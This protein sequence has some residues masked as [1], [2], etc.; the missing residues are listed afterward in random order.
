MARLLFVPMS[1]GRGMGPLED[2]LSV[3]KQASVLGHTVAFVCR[4]RFCA[5]PAQAGYRVYPNA[6]P[7]A[8][9]TIDSDL[10]NVDFPV[11]QGL[12]EEKWVRKILACE[13]AAI[14]DFRPHAV[15]TWLQFTAAI[16][17]RVAGVPI[18]SV[19]RWT[20]HPEFASPL[21][22]GRFLRSGC[23][24]LFNRILAEYELPLI[25]DVW[26][27]DFFRSDLKIVAGTPELE[28]GLASVSNLYYV[29]HLLPS[30]ADKTKLSQEL[31]RWA[32]GYPAVFVYL[33]VKQFQPEEYCPIIRKAF[34]GSEFRAV[35][36]VGL[37]DICPELPESTSNVRFVRWIPI[38]AMMSI[39]DVVVSTGTRGT[40][41]QAALHGAG[42]VAFPGKDP[43]RDFVA[44]MLETAGAGIRLPDEAFTPKRI[45]SAVRE[46]LNPVTR[47][48]AKVLGDQLR[49]LGG[50]KRAAELLVR[51]AQGELGG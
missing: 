47:A 18:A 37:K 20:G 9:P 42:H 50:P 15:F 46:V 39:S 48:H 34:D 5:L 44:R 11:F 38:D 17:A 6:T 1:W 36:A 10:F 33:S 29:G 28:P 12:G 2:C 16:S 35:V 43:E 19:A 25:D 51:L 41:W 45:L 26:E 13:F 14:E 40:S 8:P 30:E 31:T 24:P 4:E 7:P 21:L 49:S 32:L 23:T 27:L 22:G 3:A